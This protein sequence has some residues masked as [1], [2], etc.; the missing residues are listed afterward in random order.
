MWACGCLSRDVWLSVACTPPCEANEAAAQ[1]L[2]A[3]RP[4]TCSSCQLCTQKCQH[5]ALQK[6]Q[7]HFSLLV[8]VLIKNVLFQEAM[9]ITW[10]SVWFYPNS[11]HSGRML[12]AWGFISCCIC[13]AHD[14]WSGRCAQTHDQHCAHLIA[15]TFKLADTCMYCLGAQNTT[16]DS[17]KCSRYSAELLLL[18]V[19]THRSRT[20]RQEQKAVWQVV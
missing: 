5:L 16:V 4:T 20:P 15:V 14:Q 13:N 1:C 7:A 8:W 18:T 10:Q 12:T 11:S 3:A 17:L 2:A 6:A 19:K 9:T